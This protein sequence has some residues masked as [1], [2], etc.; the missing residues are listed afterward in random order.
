MT[1]M[2]SVKLKKKFFAHW[3]DFINFGVPPDKAIFF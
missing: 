1:K 2:S 3:R